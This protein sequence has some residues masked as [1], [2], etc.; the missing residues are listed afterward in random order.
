M[1]RWKI[2]TA[3]FFTP[4]RRGSQRGSWVGLDGDP[5]GFRYDIRVIA[6]INLRWG[7]RAQAH[8]GHQREC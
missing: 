6:Q 1:V 8:D 2:L 4:I 3:H 5:S 7:E